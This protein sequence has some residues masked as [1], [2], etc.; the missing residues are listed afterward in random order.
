MLYFIKNFEY[1]GNDFIIEPFDLISL[2]TRR[3][4]K[5]FEK[6]YREYIG[7]MPKIEIMD[8]ISPNY[9]I[10]NI[11][12]MDLMQ[13]DR[14]LREGLRQLNSYKNDKR[15]NESVE[16]F[17]FYKNCFPTNTILVNADIIEEV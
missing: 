13:H 17:Y 12:H 6:V 10:K 3:T 5:K 1:D 14:E 4:M 2:L 15:M 11:N 9:R 8:M 16:I 7:C